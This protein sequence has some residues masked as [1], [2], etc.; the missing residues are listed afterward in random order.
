MLVKL[1]PHSDVVEHL[2]RVTGHR[3]ASKAYE[4]AGLE[5]PGMLACISDQSREIEELQQTIQV[6][7]FTMKQ[8]RDAA[9]LLVERTSQ[10]DLFTN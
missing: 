10:K 1:T 4:Q 5:Y 7:R 8:A 3:T 9:L 2:K 6:L